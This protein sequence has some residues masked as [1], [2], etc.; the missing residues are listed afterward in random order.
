MTIE[1]AAK[2]I[3]RHN[4]WRRG[5]WDTAENPKVLGVAIDIIIEYIKTNTTFALQ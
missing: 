2:I 4:E 3:E 1:E 5:K